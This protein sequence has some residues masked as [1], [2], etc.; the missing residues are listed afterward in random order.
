M[1]SVF[2]PLRSLLFSRAPRASARRRLAVVGGILG[3]WL[4]VSACDITLSPASPPFGPDD[5]VFEDPDR[6]VVQD[7]SVWSIDEAPFVVEGGQPAIVFVYQQS[8]DPLLP[9][10]TGRLGGA[11]FPVYSAPNDDSRL[12]F[13]APAPD[14]PSGSYELQVDSVEGGAFTEILRRSSTPALT[15]SATTEALRARLSG[16]PTPVEAEAVRAALDAQIQALAAL[17]DE[18]AQR[19]EDE[20]AALRRFLQGFLEGGD[21][22]SKAAALRREEVWERAPSGAATCS[23]LAT[24]HFD[25]HRRLEVLLATL[26]SDT[27][28]PP[29]SLERPVGEAAALLMAEA[30]W[31]GE[32]RMVAQ[33]GKRS[34]ELVASEDTSSLD[35]PVAFENDRAR[36]FDVFIPV[37]EPLRAFDVADAI[38]AKGSRL[39]DLLVPAMR[40]GR[41]RDDT[42][43]SFLPSLWA[44]R[45]R[46]FR[47]PRPDSL[48]GPERYALAGTSTPDVEGLVEPDGDGVRLTFRVPGG[49][50]SDSL[51]FSFDLRDTAV[52]FDTTWTVDAVLVP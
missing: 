50:P 22:A 43:L 13:V 11:S 40:G 49:P 24:A 5:P 30:L 46:S 32:Y 27:I 44:R 3:V 41:V 28:W 4:V 51:F 19:P 17:P 10:Y 16:L 29:S 34:Y 7:L 47:I 8:F 18:A 35:G 12:V 39:E 15:L 26:R 52:P 9:T 25:V 38:G 45:L 36:S 33:C 31:A 37:D 1:S 23:E 14:A 2:R 21:P 6:P 42:W 20:Q 48:A